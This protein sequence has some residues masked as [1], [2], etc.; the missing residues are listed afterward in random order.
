MT[1]RKY[2]V[3]LPGCPLVK[4]M[5]KSVKKKVKKAKKKAKRIEEVE[6]YKV[7]LIYDESAHGGEICEGEEGSNYPEHEPEYNEFYPKGLRL[8]APDWS[9]TIEV[10][11]DPSGLDQLYVVIVRYSSGSTFGTTHGH[12]HVIGAYESR[13]EA[14]KIEMAISKGTG[15]YN[16]SE[17]GLYTDKNRAYMP[18]VG[19]FESLEEV[20]VER[21]DIW[22]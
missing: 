14:E 12:W 22:K 8:K 20:T 7:Y 19:Y 3:Q 13:D 2:W 15:M 17:K 21:L 4:T 11:F 5:A 9:E 16:R 18:W 10:D 1:R 6:A